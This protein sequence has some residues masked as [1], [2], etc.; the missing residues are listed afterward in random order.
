MY[1][2]RRENMEPSLLNVLK[3]IYAAD[4]QLLQTVAL[5]CKK[6]APH[7]RCQRLSI[8]FD[9]GNET[10]VLP[11]NRSSKYY[12]EFKKA[13]TVTAGTLVNKKD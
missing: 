11:G 12:R 5:C 13:T 4:Y 3:V 10:Y 8:F 9:E 2:K 7:Y 6:Q 1:V